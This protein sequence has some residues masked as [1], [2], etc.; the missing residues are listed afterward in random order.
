MARLLSDG[1]AAALAAPLREVADEREITYGRSPEFHFN[2]ACTTCGDVGY[3][4]LVVRSG[5]MSE[6]D[7]TKALVQWIRAALTT[8]RGY[9]TI[10]TQQFGAD[11]TD[12]LGLTTP[13]VPTIIE[14][15]TRDALLVDDRIQAVDVRVAEGTVEIAVTTFDGARAPLRLLTRVT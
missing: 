13:E 7:G 14:Q 15:M 4:H 10:Y 3:P 2:P 1:A 5:R 6:V 9:H 12:V 8:D 11:Y